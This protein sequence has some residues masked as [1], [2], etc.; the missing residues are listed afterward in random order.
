MANLTGSESFET[1]VKTQTMC[2]MPLGGHLFGIFLSYTSHIPRLF[3]FL[4]SP[5]VVLKHVKAPQK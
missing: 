2:V 5:S 4:S 1:I 3:F